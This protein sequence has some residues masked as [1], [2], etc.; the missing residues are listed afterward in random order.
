M[1]VFA[2][3]SRVGRKSRG[4]ES[5]VALLQ[6]LLLSALISLMAIS[7]TQTAREQIQ[8]AEQFEGRVI[9]ELAVYS[10]INE[11]IFLLLAGSDPEQTSLGGGSARRLPKKADLN[12]HGSPIVWGN[13]VTIVL[14]DL[15][16]LLPQ[17]FPSH[18]LW[19]Q[20]LSS[21]SV[22]ESD[23]DS[24]LGSWSDMQDSDRVSWSKGL[25]PLNLP[26]GHDYL[27]GFAQNDK[28]LELIFATDKALIAHLLAISDV[29]A[30]TDT[31]LFN[32]PDL[33]LA[34]ILDVSIAQEIIDRRNLSD[35]SVADL[36]RLLPKKPGF[37]GQFS[38]YSGRFKI[39]V[40]L[41]RDGNAWQ[42]QITV[43]LNATSVKPF[44]VISPN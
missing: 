14:Q 8:M 29:N 15:D 34:S 26:S 20:V 30:S 10:A 32:S 42:E 17:L 13:G 37:D 39:R 19:R 21:R 24:Y 5:G 3:F 16:A 36:R 9:A 40:V 2:S 38:A 1:I 22:P 43:N 11:V 44:E 18:A 35:F 7:F 28:V 33:L 4:G 31:N 41:A 23:I 25:E 27:N 6:V 12:F